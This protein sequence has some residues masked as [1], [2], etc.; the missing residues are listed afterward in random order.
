MSLTKRVQTAPIAVRLLREGIL[1]S[2]HLV[3]AVVCDRRGRTLFIAGNP[4][5]SSFIRSALKPLQALVVLKTGTMERFGLSDRDLAIICSSHKGSVEQARQAFNILWKADI[6]Q[7]AL[8]CP[9]PAGRRSP[10]EYNCSGKH[11]GMLAASKQQNWPL[12]GYM[13]R[14]HPVQQAI[15]EIVG[16]LLGI[17]AAEFIVARDDCGVPTVSME[18]QQMATLYAH[19][20]SGDSPELERIQRAMTYHPDLIAG[21]GEFDTELMRLT[22][23][24]LV[25]KTGAEGVQCIG[26]VGEGLG[27]A[28][29]VQDGAKRAKIAVA[30]QSLRQIGWIS[31]AIADL[32]AE[33]FMVIAPCK[34]LEVDGELTLL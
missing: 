33:Q 25:S 26:Q 21:E 27:L 3:E 20:S 30:I 34:R 17:P 28:I 15:L 22:E 7:A 1:E 11:A 31:P 8:Q 24:R 23:G 2:S 19:L 4:E 12:E 6:D 16:D 14:S 5:H 10:L 18:L 13:R 32:L 29:K 9:T